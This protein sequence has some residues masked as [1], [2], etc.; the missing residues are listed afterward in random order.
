MGVAVLLGAKTKTLLIGEGVDRN[1]L[2][3]IRDIAGGV[4][5]VERLGYPFT[6]FFGPHNALLT[7]T[8]QFR[9]GFSSSQVESAVDQIE[10][11]IQQRFP[12]VRHIFLEV[13]TIREFCSEDSVDEVVAP[14]KAV[15]TATE[16]SPQQ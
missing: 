3:S 11:L 4:T 7:M 8:V 16:T 15:D 9:K 14:Q 13:D 10:I 2:R 1:T 6:S 5:G 12:D